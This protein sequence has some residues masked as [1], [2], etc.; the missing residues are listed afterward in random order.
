MATTCSTD[1]QTTSLYVIHAIDTVSVQRIVRP[2][3]K[4]T[5]GPIKNLIAIQSEIN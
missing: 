2:K 3:K 1:L 5:I 4:M